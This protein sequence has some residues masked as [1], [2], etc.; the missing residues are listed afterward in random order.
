MP[1][2]GGRPSRTARTGRVVA[3]LG[4]LTL[5]ASACAAGGDP[6]KDLP[7]KLQKITPSES[8][9]PVLTHDSSRS[10]TART[11]SGPGFTM[12]VPADFEEQTSAGTGGSTI[13]RW[14]KPVEGRQPPIVAVVADP[15][16]RADAIEQSKALEISLE[17]DPAVEVIR[18]P[19]P[20]PGTQ[21]AILLQ[22]DA[23]QPGSGEVITT[24]QIMAQINPSLI[25]NALA[26]APKAQFRELTFDQI[27]ATFTPTP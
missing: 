27:L 18:S 23:P 7:E 13:Y 14:L 3:V 19:I 20:W 17:V 8:P 15:K 21:R 25:L 12:Q 4:L 22:W 9:T 24:W 6:D 11:V 16:P 5:A 26:V 10:I 2:S 1:R